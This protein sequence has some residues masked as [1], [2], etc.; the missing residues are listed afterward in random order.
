MK[1]TAEKVRDVFKDCLFRDEEV[2]KGNMDTIVVD[3]I[4]G[5]LEKV[6]NKFADNSQFTYRKNVLM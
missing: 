4:V 5:R 6:F 2:S 3:G 1:L